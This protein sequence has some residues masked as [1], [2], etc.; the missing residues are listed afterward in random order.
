MHPSEM[1]NFA[2]TAAAKAQQDGFAATA[3]ALL[4]LA[5]ACALEALELEDALLAKDG[6]SKNYAIGGE[7]C[8][9]K[10]PH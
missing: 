7:F 3:E 1:K 6:R 2:L 8:L 4:L 9:Q 5:E 10:L